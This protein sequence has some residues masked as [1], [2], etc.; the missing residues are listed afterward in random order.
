MC[1]AHSGSPLLTLVNTL[2]RSSRFK[3]SNALNRPTTAPA[4]HRVYSEQSCLQL[5]LPYWDM[6]SHRDWC[7][8]F[9][10]FK[11]RSTHYVYYQKN[12]V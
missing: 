8:P 3:I 1:A 4:G 2:K 5:N 12:R 6:S 11:I 7:I 10:I 9:F